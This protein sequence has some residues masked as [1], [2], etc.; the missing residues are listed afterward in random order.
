[1]GAAPGAGA[2]GVGA[3]AA[4]ELAGG[5]DV[6]S[7]TAV[8]AGTLP[9]VLLLSPPPPQAATPTLAAHIRTSARSRSCA[10]EDEEEL[11]V[12]VIATA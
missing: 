3:G 1:M 10:P 4:G 7:P 9:V 6:V 2:G 12:E 11:A 8:G 5:G